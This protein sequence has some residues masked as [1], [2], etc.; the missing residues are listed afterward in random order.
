[1]LLLLRHGPLYVVVYVLCKPLVILAGKKK[2]PKTREGGPQSHRPIKEHADPK[3]TAQQHHSRFY[4]EPLSTTQAPVEA[5]SS[6]ARAR[7]VS[8][9]VF[10]S[11]DF[12]FWLH[13]VST[14]CWCVSKLCPIFTVKRIVDKNGDPA[15]EN[16]QPSIKLQG[17]HA[18][19]LPLL[20]PFSCLR[21]QALKPREVRAM[22]CAR[23]GRARAGILRFFIFRPLPVD[24]QVVRW[25]R[26]AGLAEVHLHWYGFWDS[27]SLQYLR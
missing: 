8:F 19:R 2:R 5:N 9:D 12:V 17:G 23:I 22:R 25:V 1:M 6:L 14:V 15:G 24:A 3:T 13:P 18:S 20:C 21:C 4:L 7:S 26:I 27:Q 16:G 10:Y 11:P